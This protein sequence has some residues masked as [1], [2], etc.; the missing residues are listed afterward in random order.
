MGDPPELEGVLHGSDN[1]GLPD[2]IIKLLGSPSS[3]NNGV[4]HAVNASAVLSCELRVASSNV[5]TKLLIFKITSFVLVPILRDDRPSA[6][7]LYC[8]KK[9][10]GL[11]RHTDQLLPL[12]SSEP[13]GVHNLHVA[14]G[15]AFLFS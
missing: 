2:H 5:E 11:L 12:L 13:D 14:Q 1:V 3:G 10:P 4:T 8:R 9:G 6:R 15:L 7:C